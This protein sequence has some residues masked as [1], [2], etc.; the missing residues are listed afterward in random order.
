M[1]EIIRAAERLKVWI[2]QPD[3]AGWFGRLGWYAQNALNNS[4][5]HIHH[6]RRQK[7]I[8]KINSHP[9]S[10]G[11]FSHRPETLQKRI[12]QMQNYRRI[13][14]SLQK[15]HGRLYSLLFRPFFLS[16]ASSPPTVRDALQVE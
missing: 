11:F 5:S 2:L 4:I 16:K 6:T 12:L 15:N 10:Q 8:P 14:I 9:K 1:L 7:G 13:I 3:R